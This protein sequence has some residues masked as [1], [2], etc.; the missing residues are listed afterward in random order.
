[1]KTNGLPSGFR[2]LF[3][4]K[5]IKE[6]EKDMGI[7]FFDIGFG[8]VVNTQK[9]GDGLVQQT[10]HAVSLRGKKEPIGWLFEIY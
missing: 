3:T 2:Y 6:I 10:V 1:M 4:R 7:P 8:H 5:E 9:F